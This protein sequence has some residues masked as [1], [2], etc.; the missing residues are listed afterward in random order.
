M[1]IMDLKNDPVLFLPISAFSDPITTGEEYHYGANVNI[2]QNNFFRYLYV[3]DP[4]DLDESKRNYVLSVAISSAAERNE[5]GIVLVGVDNHLSVVATK[6]EEDQGYFP[7]IFNARFIAEEI[8]VEDKDFY[9]LYDGT[10][11]EILGGGFAVY[12][13]KYNI[14]WDDIQLE[15]FSTNAE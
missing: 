2:E 7:V 5:P 15:D 1:E 3:V 4:S 10:D 9:R 13:K 12:D 14:F 11:G 6:L 8:D